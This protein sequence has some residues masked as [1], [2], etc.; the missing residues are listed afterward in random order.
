MKVFNLDLY[1]FDTLYNDS[2]VKNLCVLFL[3]WFKK[4]ENKNIVKNLYG[5]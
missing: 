5:I 2:L 3:Q 4:A 1:E